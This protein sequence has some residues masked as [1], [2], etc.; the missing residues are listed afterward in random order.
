MKVILV[1]LCLSLSVN[2]FAQ[3]FGTDSVECVRNLTVYGNLYK[4]NYKEALPYW[5]SAWKNCPMSSEN[6]YVRGQEM[7]KRLISATTDDSIKEKYIDTL[8]MLHDQRLEYFPSKAQTFT[9]R[10]ILDAV[11]L[12]GKDF[13]GIYDMCDKEYQNYRE[14]TEAIVLF[15]YFQ[16]ASLLY[17]DNQKLSASKVMDIYLLVSETMQQQIASSS[18]PQRTTQIEGLKVNLDDAFVKSGVA[19]CE[20]LKNIYASQIEKS[21][22]SVETLEKAVNLL[23]ANNCTEEPLYIKACEILY[24]KK[25]SINLAI[26]IANSCGRSGEYEKAVTFYKN[27]IEQEINKIETAKYYIFAGNLLAFRLQKIQEARDFAEKALEVDPNNANAYM[28][29]GHVYA[30]DKGCGDDFEKSTRFWLSI[31]NFEKAKVDPTLVDEAT[32]YIATYRAYCPSKEDL[33]FRNIS[34]GQGYTVGCWI[35]RR[36]TARTK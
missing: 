27:A 15:Y 32:K 1:S 8:L 4:S 22:V 31:D 24:S 20:N 19:N 2:L 6:L 9:F 18:S 26:Q 11:N 34:V 14:Q 7:F 30:M 12:R 10:K 5:R 28:L 25:P 21:D 35:N 16:Y 33:F 13:Q 29:L 17:N 36:T 23:S 3:R